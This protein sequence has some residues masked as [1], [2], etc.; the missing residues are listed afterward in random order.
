MARRRIG[1][2]PLSQPMEAKLTDA[3]MRKSAS[4]GEG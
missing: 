2:K 1:D 3:C 4:M